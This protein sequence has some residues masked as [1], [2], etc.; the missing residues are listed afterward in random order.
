MAICIYC[1]EKAGIFRNYHKNCQKQFEEGRKN[2]LQ[3]IR[4]FSRNDEDIK[5]FQN[6][7]N[8]IAENSFIKGTELRNIIIEGIKNQFNTISIQVSSPINPFQKIFKI[9][10]ELNIRNEIEFDESYQEFNERLLEYL[11][12]ELADK[13]FSN[14]IA[15]IE[16][17]IK[18]NENEYFLNKQFLRKLLLKSLEKAINSFLEDGV[19]TEDEEKAIL[20]F[21]SHYNLTQEELS[22]Y[23]TYKK[24]IQSL[25]LRD[26]MNG[27]LPDRVKIKD[28]VYFNLQKNEKLIWLYNDVDYYVDTVKRHYEGGHQGASIRIAKGFYY[29]VG[30]FKG[31]PVDT[32]EKKYFG[33]GILGFTNKHLYYFSYKTSFRVRY[34]KIVS[35]TPFSNGITILKDGVTAKP[36]TFIDGDGWFSYNLVRNLSQ[37]N[38]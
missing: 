16:E 32:V 3:I 24:L 22:Q 8:I 30:G 21:K 9:I 31:R 14:G 15:E 27:I 2:I 33:K 5:G 37:L 23:D 19:I 18:R 25:I 4:A 28:Q 11:S 13:H 7:I 10:N 17:F 34:D 1:N 6:R 29:R 38:L 26:I 36:Q 35:V 12:N 20:D